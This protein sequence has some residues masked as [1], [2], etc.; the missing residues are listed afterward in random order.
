MRDSI[1]RHRTHAMHSMRDIM[2]IAQ[3]SLSSFEPRRPLNTP[4]SSHFLVTRAYLE[5]ASTC[6]IGVRMRQHT[7]GNFA[8]LAISM[9]QSRW[10][11]ELQIVPIYNAHALST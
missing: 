4:R 5:G 2:A 10:L 8:D 11:V 6:K 3:C 9:K 1:R 7:A